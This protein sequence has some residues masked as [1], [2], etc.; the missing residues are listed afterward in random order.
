MKSFLKYSKEIGNNFLLTQGPGG[1]TSTKI[2]ENIYIKKS[3]MHLSDSV[4]NSIF[5]KVNLNKIISFYETNKNNQKFEEGLSIETPIHVL[6]D[7]K[8]VFTITVFLH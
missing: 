1:N 7:E 2:S 4:N 8:H 5:Q 3:G 6:L